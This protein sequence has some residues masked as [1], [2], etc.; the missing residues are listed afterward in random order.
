MVNVFKFS[1]ALMK[2]FGSTVHQTKDDVTPKRKVHYSLTSKDPQVTDVQKWLKGQV[3]KPTPALKECAKQFSGYT[4]DECILAI[5]KW[6]KKTV[7]Y[8]KDNDIWKLLERWQEA[9]LTLS[10]KTGDCEDM[11]ILIFVLARL[12]GIPYN[13]IRLVCGKVTAGGHCWIEYRADFDGVERIIDAAYHFDPTPIRKRKLIF[14]CTEY[15]ERWFMVN[16]V[17]GYGVVPKKK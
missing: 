9:D 2:K 13:Q 11:S 15:Y 7:A 6:V 1:E 8:K 10:Q 5:L 17:N 4:K 14:E 12:N 3:D 16:D